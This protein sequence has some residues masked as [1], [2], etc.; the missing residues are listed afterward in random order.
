[1][2]GKK[3]MSTTELADLLGVS[4]VTVFKKIKSGEIPAERIGRNYAIPAK[5]V[6]RIAGHIL[7]AKEKK[8][9]DEAVR[10]IVAEY[11]ETLR[12]LGKE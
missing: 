12:L 6:Q 10:R 5:Y 11:G 2:K 1:M 3:Y 9:I 4:R 7:S 8:E